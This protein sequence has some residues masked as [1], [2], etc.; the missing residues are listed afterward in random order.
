MAINSL[1]QV[2]SG[3][4]PLQWYSKSAVGSSTTGKPYSL[5]SS[6]GSPGAGSNN[7]TLNGG[8]Y[9]STSGIPNG[10][11]PHFD[12]PGGQNSYLAKFQASATT[13]AGT[14]ILYDRLWD[15]GGYTITATTAQTIVSPTWPSRDANGT[16]NGVGVFLGVEITA[17]VGAAA[18]TITVSYTNSAGVAGRTGTNIDATFNSAATGNLFRIGLQSGDVGVQSVQSLTLSASW[19]SG[20]ISL[21]AFR[22]LALVATTATFYPNSVDPLTTG[23][24]QIFNGVVP[25]LA[26]TNHFGGGANYITAAYQETQG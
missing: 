24:P 5:W 21:V 3:M 14:L 19:I 8:T 9:S 7:S 26:F 6:G 1:N 25:F 17:T 23:F 11:I 12:P 18:P 22:Q 20:T 2:L 10:A 16:S 4:Q 13:T 15:N